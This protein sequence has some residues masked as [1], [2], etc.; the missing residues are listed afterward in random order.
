M[1]ERCAVWA[2]RSKAIAKR[3]SKISNTTKQRSGGEAVP[4]KRIGRLKLQP[5]F[6]FA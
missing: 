1:R 3:R 5:P 2:S 4:L 6:F